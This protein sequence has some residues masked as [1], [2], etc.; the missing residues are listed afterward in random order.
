MPVAPLVCGLVTSAPRDDSCRVRESSRSE[1][2]LLLIAGMG[3]AIATVFYLNLRAIRLGT[4]RARK[5]AY[6][7]HLIAKWIMIAGGALAVGVL[8]LF[9]GLV[10][11]GWLADPSGR[12]PF[13]IVSALMSMVIIP[14][15]VLTYFWIKVRARAAG[16][17]FAVIGLGVL[18]A[19]YV[20]SN[21]ML[22]RDDLVPQL[23]LWSILL[24]ATYKFGIAAALGWP[25]VTAVRRLCELAAQQADLNA[26][27]SGTERL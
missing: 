7:A 22:M 27:P 5:Q 14:F 16:L 20:T 4:E 1:V 12:F 24:I 17:I 19:V 18:L 8:L 3:A 10:I 25:I 26:C 2:P 15:C 6:A 13:G 23:P 21:V 11:S 9:L